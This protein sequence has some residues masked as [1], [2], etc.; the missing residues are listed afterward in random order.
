MDEMNKMNEE[1]LH[2]DIAETNNK[3]E[4]PKKSKLRLIID[5]IAGF[6]M[7]L[8]LVYLINSWMVIC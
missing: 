1:K 4:E 5:V 3:N 8:I 7:T 2:I 6:I